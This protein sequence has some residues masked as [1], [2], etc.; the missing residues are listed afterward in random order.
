MGLVLLLSVTLG[1]G[2]GD[3]SAEIISI[4]DISMNVRIEVEVQ[5]TALTVVAHLVAPGEPELVLP[6]LPRGGKIYGIVTDLR[7]ID[8]QVVFEALGEVSTMSQPVS[9]SAMGAQFSS[10][11]ATTTTGAEGP[12]SAV[13]RWGWLALALT[14]GSLALLAVWVLGGGDGEDRLEENSDVDSPGDAG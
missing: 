7:P 14:A 9:L 5:T 12:S 1:G 10:Q 11:A 6:L 8:Y 3:A 4:S 13:K 2:F